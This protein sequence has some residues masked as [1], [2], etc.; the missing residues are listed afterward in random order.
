[1]HCTRES[2]A[3][4]GFSDYGFTFS[5]H[6]KPCTTYFIYCS[7]RVRDRIRIRVTALFWLSVSKDTS[8]V[9]HGT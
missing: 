1:M 8:E 2:T 9:S 4:N 7:E 6:V 5:V 3:F